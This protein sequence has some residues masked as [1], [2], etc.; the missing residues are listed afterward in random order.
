[1]SSKPEASAASANT[2]R[3]APPFAG[4]STVAAI[5]REREIVFIVDNTLLTPLGQRPI[6]LGAHIS[7]TSTTK[8]IN[9]H[10]DSVGAV[11]C[12]NDPDLYAILKSFRD[13]RQ[14]DTGFNRDGVML[15]ASGAIGLYFSWREI[16]SNLEALQGETQCRLQHLDRSWLLV[17]LHDAIILGMMPRA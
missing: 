8:V 17:L 4:T 2:A 6:D 11:L 5:C 9:G 15:V 16:Q 14:N 12:M 13:T 10:G 1:V 3:S 7:L